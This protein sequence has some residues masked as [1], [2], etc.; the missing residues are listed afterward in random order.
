MASLEEFEAR[1]RGLP[2]NTVQYLAELY[3]GQDQGQEQRS[4][5]QRWL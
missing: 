4:D 2:I 1:F 5:V 3:S